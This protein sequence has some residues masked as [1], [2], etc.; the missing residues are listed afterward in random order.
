MSDDV[1]TVGRVYKP[2]DFFGWLMCLLG[3]S[4]MCK[5]GGVGWIFGTEKNWWM[6]AVVVFVFFDYMVR[7]AFGRVYKVVHFDSVVYTMYEILVNDKTFF[8]C[9][10]SE[11]ELAL[12][13]EHKYP[14]L[15]Y[16]VLGENTVESFVKT[17]NHF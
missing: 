8:V 4:L 15:E 17:E 2:F 11:E 10:K 16:K 12:Y 7:V 14:S 6:L 5:F 1:T 9:A 3:I 13:M